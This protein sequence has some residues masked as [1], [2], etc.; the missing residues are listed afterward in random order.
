VTADPVRLALRVRPNAR[1]NAVVGFRD[2]VLHLNIAAPAVDGR[3]NQ[4]LVRYL[5]GIL[6]IRQS[7]VRIER[8]AT[9]RDK[10]VGVTGVDRERLFQLLRRLTGEGPG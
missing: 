9:G 4:E 6:S 10:L 2:N 8:G 3:A 7:D 1:H 5:S